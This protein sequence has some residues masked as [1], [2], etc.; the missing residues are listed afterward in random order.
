MPVRRDLYPKDIPERDG[1]YPR[2]GFTFSQLS[3]YNIYMDELKAR[4]AAGSKWTQLPCVHLR[5]QTG[6]EYHVYP[7]E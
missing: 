2:K 5:K 3:D 6:G 1:F 7:E 4:I